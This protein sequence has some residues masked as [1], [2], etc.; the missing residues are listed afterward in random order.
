MYDYHTHSWVE[1]GVT[2]EDI[3]G[4]KPTNAL[5]NSSIPASEQNQEENS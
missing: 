3:I 1:T 4:K 2:K 5:E